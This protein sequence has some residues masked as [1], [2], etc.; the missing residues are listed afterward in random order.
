MKNQLYKVLRP[1]IK[2]DHQTEK[3]VQEV[4]DLFYEGKEY[5]TVIVDKK[6][7]KRRVEGGWLYSF[8]EESTNTWSDKFV[9]K[10]VE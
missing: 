2:T 8:W 10:I 1:F 7:K 6:T 4:L 3:A 5:Q 9:P